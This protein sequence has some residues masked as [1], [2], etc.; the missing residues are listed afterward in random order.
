[1]EGLNA[2]KVLLSLEPL[3]LKWTAHFQDRELREE[4]RQVA[5]VACWK[6]LAYFDDTRGKSMTSYFFMVVR[7]ALINW[8]KKEK[9]Y[10]QVHLLPSDI[11]G[12]EGEEGTWE[13]RV[14]DPAPV[15]YGADL[16]WNAW[17]ES[18]TGWERTCLTLHLRDGYSL[19]EVAEMCQ[20]PY[21]R[22]KKWK[23]RGLARLR[24]NVVE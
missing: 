14:A 20:V 24:K 16:I 8:Y 4:A 5:R 22:V 10:Q 21:E 12:E 3:I 23:Q 2:Q 11:T 15:P 18:L 6:R 9:R 13:E 1:M 19:M 7:S 17:M